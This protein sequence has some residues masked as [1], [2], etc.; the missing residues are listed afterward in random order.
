M[1][2]FPMSN[3]RNISLLGH[4]RSGKTTLV[5]SLLYHSG[6]IP[7]MGDT[8]DGSTVCDF[9]EEEQARGISLSLAVASLVHNGTKINLVDTPGDPSFLGE[10][11]SGVSVTELTLILVDAVAGAEVGT[12]LAWTRIQAEGQPVAI[13][14]NKMDRENADW[15]R[16][17]ESLGEACPGATLVPFHLPIGQALDFRGIVDLVAEVAWMGDGGQT[18]ELPHDLSDEIEEARMVLV[19]AAAESD[20]ELM[21]KY[22]EG[23]D[24]SAAEV[25]KGLAAG[26]AGGTI[27]PVFVC[28]A[29]AGIGVHSLLDRLVEVAPGADQA[30][31]PLVDGGQPE[32]G[33]EAPALALT[34]RTIIDRYRGRINYVRVFSGTLVKGGMVKCSGSPAAEP[35]VNLHA[36]QGNDLD[37]QDAIGPGD[38]GAVSKLTGVQSGQVLYDA[39]SEPDVV[40]PTYPN[41]LFSMAVA[42]ATQADSAKLGQSLSQVAEED[43]TLSIVNI[44]ETKQTVI[45]GVGEIQVDVALKRLE[46]GFGVGVLASTPKVPYMET[47]TRVGQAQYRHKKQSGGAGQF[48]E[49]H[50]RVEPLDRGSGFEYESEIYGGA[51]S[52]VYLPSIEKGVKQVMDEG[53]VAGFPA[54]DLKVVVFDGKE[55]P[56]DSKD[57]AFQI[58]G[59]EVFKMAASEAGATLL[60]PIY[61]MDISVPEDC[62]GDIMGDLTNRRGRVLGMEQETNRSVVKAEV[63]FA[64]IMR[65]GT[66][67][68]SMTQGR[69]TYEIDFLHYEEVPK[70]LVAKVIEGNKAEEE[71]E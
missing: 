67:L 38:I 53:V 44:P 66:D 68:R 27:V 48:A 13:L 47:V 18:S 21:E 10:V 51:I 20:D 6:A 29:T 34:F 50:M 1:A 7:R 61:S 52:S 31:L 24:L 40:L 33:A 26:V 36:A 59:R 32:S 5:E 60:E 46:S 41:P 8:A 42:P 63:P 17:L 2:E 3:I 37:N 35:L 57:I 55:H 28:S 43:P 62:M 15:D 30:E 65:Y 11:I 54:V 70:H 49:V 14:V 58:A 45:Q 16:A 9:D 22:L 12:E 71:D 39:D 4:S 56:V 23:E 25:K 19:E 69:G 64:E